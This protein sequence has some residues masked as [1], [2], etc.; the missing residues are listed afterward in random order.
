MFYLF[1]RLILRIVCDSWLCMDFPIPESGMALLLKASNLRRA[2][3]KLLNAKLDGDWGVLC[4]SRINCIQMFV[5]AL[6]ENVE[7][8]LKNIPSSSKRLEM[9]LWH[10]LAQFMACQVAYT[11]KRL[12]PADLKVIIYVYMTLMMQRIVGYSSLI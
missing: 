8:A 10:D 4:V 6:K 2:W 7:N 1:N 9:E 11:L 5:A 12:L 3:S